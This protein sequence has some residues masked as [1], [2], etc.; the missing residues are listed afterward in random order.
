M[1]S[2]WIIMFDLNML[3]KEA[4]RL[5][6]FFADDTTIGTMLVESFLLICA[7]PKTIY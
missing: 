3:V 7:S 2:N 1:Q 5:I 6:S 4:L